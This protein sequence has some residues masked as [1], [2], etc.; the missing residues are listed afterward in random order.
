MSGIIQSM[1]NANIDGSILLILPLYGQI[2]QTTKLVI[3][4]L[5]FFPENKL[6]ISY[7]L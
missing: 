6:G 3:F 2:Q 7:K 5:I 1:A 4:L